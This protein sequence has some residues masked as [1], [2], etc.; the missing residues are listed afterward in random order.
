MGYY[1]NLL[2]FAV[3]AILGTLFLGEQAEN[4]EEQALILSILSSLTFPLSLILVKNKPK[5]NKE[6]K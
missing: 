2:G 3:G 6:K 4:F 5:T 1:M